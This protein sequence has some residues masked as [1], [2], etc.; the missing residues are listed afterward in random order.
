[1]DV[2]QTAA[3]VAVVRV[4]VSRAESYEVVHC[5]WCLFSKQLKVKPAH[6]FAIHF[7]IKIGLH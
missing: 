1:M 6:I 3:S 7:N 2:L 5:L 4:E